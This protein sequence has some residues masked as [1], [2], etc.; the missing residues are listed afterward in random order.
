MIKLDN[1]SKEP[2][3]ELA[4]S[5]GSI[6]SKWWWWN[7]DSLSLWISIFLLLS[8]MNSCCPSDIC[9]I[10]FPHSFHGQSTVCLYPWTSITVSKSRLFSN[11][12]PASLISLVAA[13]GRM[14]AM[15]GGLAQA[16]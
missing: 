9:I 13:L 6:D 11:Q 2:S 1:P 15:G 16:K 5:K 8:Y 7:Y 10:I 3:A 4:H 14:G 12:Y